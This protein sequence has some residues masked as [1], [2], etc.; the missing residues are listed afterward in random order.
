[1]NY[2]ALAWT[3]DAAS[4]YTSD[5]GGVS[6]NVRERPPSYF[7]LES[8]RLKV[9][10]RQELGSMLTSI[11][12]REQTKAERAANEQAMANGH[13]APVPAPAPAPAANGA[14]TPAATARTPKARL[15]VLRHGY[16]EY[17]AENRFTG[18]VQIWIE[19]DVP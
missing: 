11:R 1:M 19:P 18:W 9:Q 7:A 13:A 6:Y 15:I 3:A 2:S 8:E 5:I 4:D 16:S 10:A 17:N 14:A 12:Q